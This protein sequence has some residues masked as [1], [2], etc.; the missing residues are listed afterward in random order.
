LGST[1][2]DAEV[3]DWS[4]DDASP[5]VEKVRVV[6]KTTSHT[7]QGFIGA[8]QYD[9]EN[10]EIMGLCFDKDSTIEW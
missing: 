7:G 4:V 3:V 1:Y 9:C 8:H 10:V 5:G 2:T 6:L